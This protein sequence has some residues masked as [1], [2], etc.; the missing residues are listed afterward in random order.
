MRCSLLGQAEQVLRDLPDSLRKNYDAI[1][2]MLNRRFNRDDMGTAHRCKFR[3]R[4]QI[5]GESVEQYVITLIS[6][7]DKAL[8]NHSSAQR[9]IHVME[10]FALSRGH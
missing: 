9:E 5:R 8:P 1:V 7:A 3:E 4:R 6:L 2:T 10:Q